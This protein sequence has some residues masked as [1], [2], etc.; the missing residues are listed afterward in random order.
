MQYSGT[1]TTGISR[2]VVTEGHQLDTHRRVSVK[3]R[4][5][6]QRPTLGTVISDYVWLCDLHRSMNAKKRSLRERKREQNI[7]ATLARGRLGLQIAHRPARLVPLFPV[8]SFT[9]HSKCAHHG[10]IE[11]GSVFCCMVC[12]A[13]GQDDHPAL[14]HTYSVEPRS[15]AKH[16]DIFPSS[17]YSDQKAFPETR[18]QRRQR[19]FRGIVGSLRV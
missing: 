4:L 9:P 18:K 16:E 13:S 8:G 11:R 2:T 15:E 10:P 7:P 14:Q 19:L 3:S 6:K 5:S 12:H 1:S 17:R